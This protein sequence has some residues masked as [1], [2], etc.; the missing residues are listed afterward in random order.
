MGR[1]GDWGDWQ[2]KESKTTKRRA[3][4]RKPMDDPDYN[5]P[6]IL[7]QFIWKP[8][9]F[10]GKWKWLVFA[11]CVVK[12]RQESFLGGPKNGDWLEI[13]DWA[14]NQAAVILCQ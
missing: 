14:E 6:F 10:G 8:R 11:Q 2:I 7:R 5:T 13:I 3:R 4:R 12:W 9:C 1:S